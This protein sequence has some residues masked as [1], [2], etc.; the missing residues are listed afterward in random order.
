MAAL[1]GLVLGCIASL[2]GIT[3]RVP[4]ESNGLT[5]PLGEAVPDGACPKAAWQ[6][7]PS[8]PFQKLVGNWK[9]QAI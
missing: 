1:N 6:S 4:R 3:E 7:F 9:D 5:D 2:V 8:L